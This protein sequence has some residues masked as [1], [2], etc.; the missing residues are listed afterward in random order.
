MSGDI[1]PSSL[2]VAFMSSLIP[3]YSSIQKPDRQ[4]VAP[5]SHAAAVSGPLRQSQ[6]DPSLQEAVHHHLTVVPKPELL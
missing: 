6:E 5:H 2:V 4:R 3:R 1:S